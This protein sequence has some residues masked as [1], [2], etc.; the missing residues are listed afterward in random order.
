M[1]ENNIEIIIIKHQLKNLFRENAKVLAIL[2][3]ALIKSENI[4]RDNINTSNN[5]D[6]KLSATQQLNMEG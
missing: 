2:F 1:K 3:R 5:I 4:A 6:E